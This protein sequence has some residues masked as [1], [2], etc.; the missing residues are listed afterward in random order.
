MNKQC[1][2][3][4]PTY[5]SLK[6]YECSVLEN[7]IHMTDGY[8]KV[9]I[10][11]QSFQFDATYSELLQS[12]EVVRFGD[13]FFKGIDGYNR[14]MLSESFYEKFSDY[15]YMLIHQLDAY[16]FKAELA[17]WCSLG[18]DYIGAPWYKANR[19]KADIDRSWKIKNI[20]FIYSSQK[21]EARR[22]WLLIDEVGNGGFSLRKIET[23]K[24]VLAKVAPN[25]IS[26][27]LE[28]SSH[29]YNEDVFWAIEASKYKCNY[30]K[31][32]FEE[33]LRFSIEMD[34][35][36]CFELLGKELPF[37]C[38]AFNRFGTDFWR[39]FIPFL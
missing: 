19:I 33:A 5:T 24:T 35:S 2:V 3:I 21:R 22:A 10:A 17:Y 36:A 27:Y 16:I 28:N 1:I 23:F 34:P 20:P 7:A 29:V 38:H 15:E 4:F 32:K 12:L 11:P 30:K 25:V 26:K 13:S 14:L 6:S 31:P 8:K 37:G 18:Y 39:Q 9:F